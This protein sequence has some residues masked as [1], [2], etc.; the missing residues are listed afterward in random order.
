MLAG[1]VMQRRLITVGEDED[2]WSVCWTLVQHH[3]TGAPVMDAKGRLVGVISQTDLARYLWNRA[4][5]EVSGSAVGGAPRAAATAGQLMTRKLVQ[6]PPEASLREVARLM[7]LRNVHRVL[8]T[9]G[10]R[11]LGLGSTMDIV[12]AEGRRP[13][14]AS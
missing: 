9:R 10:R 12:A 4:G 5:D 2:V 14:K 8:I 7:T 3:V 1:D 11:L 13:G 6:A